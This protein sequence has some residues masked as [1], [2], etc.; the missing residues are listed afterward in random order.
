MNAIQGFSNSSLL[1]LIVLL[2]NSTLLL[3]ATLLLQIIPGLSTGLIPAKWAC[4]LRNLALTS[5]WIDCL[6]LRSGRHGL[7]PG[8]LS[9]IIRMS[10]P[11]KL[12]VLWISG[13]SQGDP[14]PLELAQ[15]GSCRVSIFRLI[16]VLYCYD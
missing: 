8:E 1:L 13:L 7:L 9:P 5:Y 10:I 6:M 2:V 12:S 3:D 4:S 15:A 11:L 16:S 14:A